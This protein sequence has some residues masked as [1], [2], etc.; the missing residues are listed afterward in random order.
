MYYA[1]T[2][3]DN[4]ITGVHEGGSPIEQGHFSA[5]P[6]LANDTVFAIE[7][8]HDYV[9]GIDIRCYN[10]DGSMKPELWCIEQGYLALPPNKEIINGELVDKVIPPEAQPQNIMQ[11]LNAQVVEMRNEQTQIITE[12]KEEQL[13]I[14]E[15]IRGKQAQAVALVKEEQTQAVEI[16]KEEYNQRISVMKPLMTELVKDKPANIVISASEFIL[17]WVPDSY[18]IGDIRK[19]STGYPKKCIT[20]HNSLTNPDHTI[21]VASLWAPFHA[22]Q[23]TYALPWIAPTGTHDM[24][25]VGEY[26]IF[27]D[28]KI[29]KCVMDTNFSPTDYA[30]TWIIDGEEPVVPE[31]LE[32]PE[33]TY[34]SN[35]TVVGSTWVPWNSYPATLYQVGDIVTHNSIRYSATTGNNHWEPGV[36]GWNIVSA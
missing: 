1:L 31:E 32:E 25:K 18:V 35:G 20:A 2:I 3:R 26:M 34:N 30:Q 4:L 6:E 13:L 24:Y 33:V 14:L 23:S 16:V 12:M 7:G 15:D 27:T 9:T 11:L 10:D 21:D 19:D 29:Y 22:T 28:K 8:T 17:D 5:N 36:F